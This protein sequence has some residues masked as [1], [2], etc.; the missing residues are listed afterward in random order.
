[1]I[2]LLLVGKWLAAVL[3]LLVTPFNVLAEQ[4]YHCEMTKLGLIINGEIRFKTLTEI[5]EFEVEIDGNILT[6]GNYETCSIKAIERNID[7]VEIS[8]DKRN[9]ILRNRI[10]NGGLS[11]FIV[12]N[13]ATISLGNED[14][15]FKK[16]HLKLE[17]G[18]W[19]I[20]NHIYY[21]GSCKPTNNHYG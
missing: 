11:E 4:A 19:L 18:E 8:C 10:R 1:M 6:L 13:R 5:K 2:M 17:D 14:S 7:S 12:P 15:V 9:T 16:S 20:I 21:M 3:L